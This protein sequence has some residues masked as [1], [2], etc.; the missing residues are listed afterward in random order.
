[1]TIFRII[2]QP[3]I[4]LVLLLLGVTAYATDEV[5]Q[6]L[7][8]F[9]SEGR[10]AECEQHFAKLGQSPD[11]SAEVHTALGLT[12]FIQAIEFLGQSGYR[13][14]LISHQ[15]RLIPL[16]RMPVPVNPKPE[17]LSYQQLRSIISELQT[18]LQS[19]ESSLAV[20]N[21]KSMKLRFYI[22]KVVLDLDQNGKP[23]ERETLWRIFAE[24]NRGMDVSRIET[25]NSEAI[26]NESTAEI[27]QA[28]QEF[29]VAVDGTDV[30]WLR[31]YCHFL[32]A[33]CDSILAY[34]QQDLFER[35]G[36]LIFP[37]ID[38]PYLISP[39]PTAREN[40]GSETELVLDAIAAFHLIDF[41]LVDG[42]RM[43]SARQHLLMVIRQSRESWKRAFEE[44]DDDHEWIPNPKQTGILNSPVGNELIEGW[45]KVLNE[46][47]S[48]LEGKKLAPFVRDEPFFG[49]PMPRKAKRGINLQKFFDEASDFD[50]ILSIQGSGVKQ[51]L[52]EGELSDA[53]TWAEL[54]RVFRGDFFGFAVWFN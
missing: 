31:G 44:T 14:G 20:A 30:H 27:R 54:T 9:L 28:A 18:K 25:A 46:M 11:A 10:L 35:C 50:L 33:F 23:S 41:K 21:T 37:N 34:D 45:S 39:N 1:M 2:M 24:F 5:A 13:Y 16:F 47:E 8:R 4:L 12:R 6:E 51:Y 53:A 7:D 49:G 38:S 22:G 19:A 29:H 3:L 48:L 43:K 15:A 32:M 36:Q 52:Q 42:E 40:E 26:S 17:K